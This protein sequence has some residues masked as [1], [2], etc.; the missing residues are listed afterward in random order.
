MTE[1][2]PTRPPANSIILCFC[3]LS[4]A[5]R[6]AA[7]A[8]LLVT[9]VNVASAGESKATSGTCVAN[10]AEVAGLNADDSTDARAV[11]RYKEAVAQL[12][13]EG[14][15][16]QLDCLADSARLHKEKFSG[17]MWKLH[18]LY[19]G[20]EAPLQH[21]TPEDW[22]TH[23]RVVKR[24]VSRKPHSITARVALAESYLDYAGD[25][26]GDGFADTVSASGWK[27]F[28]ERTAQARQVL[29]KAATLHTRCPEW[30]LAMQR[31]AL[32]QS[33]SV[34]DARAL[35]DQA[36]AFEPDYYYY[37]RMYVTFL[38]PKWNGEPGDSEKAMQAAADRIGG[39]RGDILYFEI[40]GNLICRCNNEV[41][42]NRV[43]WPR[44]QRGFDL[45]EKQ[46]GTS[47]TNLNL[48]SFMAIKF[49]DFFLADQ[50]FTRIHDQWSSDTWGNQ[51]YFESWKDYSGKAAQGLAQQH[52]WREAAD[53]NMRT[54]EGPAYQSAFEDKFRDFVQ[55]CVQSVGPDDSRFEILINVGQNGFVEGWTASPETTVTRCLQQTLMAPR[56]GDATGPFPRPPQPHYWLRLDLDP[57]TYAA[58][59]PN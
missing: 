41:Q 33:W 31:V 23:L 1:P 4:D 14:S 32:A 2:V 19:A 24:W 47:I 28:E 50:L 17:G 13:D 56:R 18:L 42:L 16:E 52:S 40:A 21:A 34:P 58:A 30:Y 5:L 25:M 29:E 48:L 43:S 39:E 53:A 44:I 46:Y 45:L 12:L 59:A 26:R 15:Y 9:A 57:T 35:L 11:R 20:V 49:K 10:D 51:S 55:K 27:L 22:N 6:F 3:H 54:G 7:A 38:L 36:S 8:L 37:H